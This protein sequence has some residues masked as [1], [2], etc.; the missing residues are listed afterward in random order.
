MRCQTA[1]DTEAPS[2]TSI[3]HT[4]HHY[5]FDSF[6][7][8]KLHQN[9]QETIPLTKIHK[10]CR[11]NTITCKYERDILL[12]HVDRGGSGRRCSV[13]KFKLRDIQPKQHQRRKSL[14][15]YVKVF[16]IRIPATAVLNSL[17][18]LLI[19]STKLRRCNTPAFNT[20]NSPRSS[21]CILLD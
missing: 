2:L 17:L 20:A 4:P 15:Y 6:T 11:C 3:R 21:H 13:A 12:L 9:P 7:A 5:D 18:V 19:Y 1:R 8:L 10:T 14:K 16:L